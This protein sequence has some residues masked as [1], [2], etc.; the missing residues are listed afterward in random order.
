[1]EIYLELV[2]F[3]RGVFRTPILGGELAETITYNVTVAN[4]GGNKYYIS[5]HSGSAP[6]LTLKKGN[7]YR[8]TRVQ[9]QTITTHYSFLQHLMERMAVD[10]LIQRE[11]Q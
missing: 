5:D 7:T 8:L 4:D 10:Q 2:A 11:L 9:L 1:M 6:T 3:P